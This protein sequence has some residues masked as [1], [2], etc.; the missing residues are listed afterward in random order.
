MHIFTGS[1]SLFQENAV[2]I[3]PMGGMADAYNNHDHLSVIS[4]GEIWKGEIGVH[5]S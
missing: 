4:G 2:A 5:V 1:S 3:E